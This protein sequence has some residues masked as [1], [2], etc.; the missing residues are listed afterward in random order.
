MHRE[1]APRSQRP[2]TLCSSKSAGGTVARR[3]GSW[4]G[5]ELREIGWA[6]GSGPESRRELI[7]GIGRMERGKG[8]RKSLG[9]LKQGGR[10]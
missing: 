5:C 9:P 1:A 6:Q 8:A 10:E 3:L 7:G 2:N 4:S